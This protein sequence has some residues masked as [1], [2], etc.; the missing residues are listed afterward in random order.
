[1]ST[2]RNKSAEQAAL[3]EGGHKAEATADNTLRTGAHVAGPLPAM[4]RAVLLQPLELLIDGH[5]N[6][7]SR[8]TRRALKH[9]SDRREWRQQAKALL[10]AGQWLH[11]LRSPN[12]FCLLISV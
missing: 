2:V 6:T 11:T 1:M 8:A 12:S 10:C 5:T 4:P 3:G 9:I 7:L